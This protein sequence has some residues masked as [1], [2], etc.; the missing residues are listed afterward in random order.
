[1]ELQEDHIKNLTL[2]EVEQILRQLGKSLKDY[3]DMPE[4]NDE[5]RA[6]GGNRFLLE[7]LSYDKDIMY[8][9]HESMF[10]KLNPDQLSA[11]CKIM[12]AVDSKEGGFFFF[13]IWSRRNR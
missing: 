10:S 3:T 8:A 6:I 5:F 12:A 2:I 4:P 11:Y 1:M 9:E 7:E 13:S